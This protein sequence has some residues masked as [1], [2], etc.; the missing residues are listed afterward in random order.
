MSRLSTPDQIIQIPNPQPIVA[1][2]AKKSATAK[3]DNQMQQRVNRCIAAMSTFA[4]FV[5]TTEG[6]HHKYLT[7]NGF[8]SITAPWTKT[9]HGHYGIS[10][11][12]GRAL[13]GIITGLQQSDQMMPWVLYDDTATS[14]Y[15]D[16]ATYPTRAD[17]VVWLKFMQLEKTFASHWYACTDSTYTAH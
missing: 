2:V 17:A 8:L 7:R 3:R 9:G 5:Y 12:D 1:P 15:V 10:R 4:T 13:H 16:L 11:S 6:D 14:W